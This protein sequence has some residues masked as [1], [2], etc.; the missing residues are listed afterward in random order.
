M[1][2][3]SHASILLETLCDQSDVVAP[4]CPVISPSLLVCGT[5]W[6]AMWVYVLWT[7]GFAVPELSGREIIPFA[8][9]K[10]IFNTIV[11]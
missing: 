8:V 2:A 3:Y 6:S 11:T 9:D 10:R 4:F 1:N 5:A 7:P